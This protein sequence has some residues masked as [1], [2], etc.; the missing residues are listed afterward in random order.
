M[1][2]GSGD[3][4]TPPQLEEAPP[5]KGSPVGVGTQETLPRQTAIQSMTG[6][7]ATPMLKATRQNHQGTSAGIPH[8]K[9]WR[10][11]PPPY[12]FPRESPKPAR[13]ERTHV[14]GYPLTALET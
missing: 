10:T 11:A 2:E 13:T 7:R 12:I 5:S 3:R 1:V 4:P 8:P 6:P 14:D 9:L